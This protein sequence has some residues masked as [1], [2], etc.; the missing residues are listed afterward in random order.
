MGGS[1]TYNPVWLSTK[2]YFILS[3]QSVRPEILKQDVCQSHHG[4]NVVVP[5]STTTL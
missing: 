3:L 5:T 2:K 4:V 1:V